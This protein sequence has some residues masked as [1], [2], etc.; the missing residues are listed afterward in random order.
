M[1]DELRELY[2]EASKTE[3]VPAADVHAAFARGVADTFR[4]P[5]Y[6]VRNTA[7]PSGW[8]ICPST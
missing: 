2:G 6:F 4:A 3:E 8:K 1:L 7:G 5:I